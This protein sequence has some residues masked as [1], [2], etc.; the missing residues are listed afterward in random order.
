LIL[1]LSNLADEAAAGF[2][3]R[4]PAGTACLVTA[5]DFH[6]SVRAAVSVSDFSASEITLGGT[7]LTAGQIRGVVATIPWFLPQEFYY[8][9]PAD[10]DYVCAEMSAFLIYFLSGLACKKLNPPSPR[11]LTGL[12]LHRLEWL[13]AAARCGVPVWPGRT[14]N[15]VPLPPDDAPGLEPVRST[16]VGGEVVGAGGPD[17]ITGYMQALSR[18]FAMPYLSGHFVS[19]NG[20]DFFLVELESVPDLSRPENCEAMVRYLN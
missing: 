8:I 9:E 7:P 6:Q 3:R 13:R 11:R 4:F 20:R 19:R 12:G 5:S 16:I 14:K 18:T 15:G 10:R 2:V 1:V 17:Q